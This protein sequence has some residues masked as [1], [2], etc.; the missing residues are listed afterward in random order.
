[1][2]TARLL[3]IGAVS[4]AAV[5]TGPAFASGNTY[6]SPLVAVLT[7]PQAPA[8]QYSAGYLDPGMRSYYS[9]MWEMARTARRQPY[10]YIPPTAPMPSWAAPPVMQAPPAM[11]RPMMQAPPAMAPH[12]MMAPPMQQPPMFQG[13]GQMGAQ[14]GVSR[15]GAEN[16]GTPSTGNPNG[17]RTLTPA[18]AAA[19]R[20]SPDNPANDPEEREKY[21][22]VFNNCAEYAAAGRTGGMLR[23]DPQRRGN[24]ELDRNGDGIACGRGD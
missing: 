12:P 17:P 2:R 18:E 6:D 19:Y 22:K 3:V 7:Y 11:Q 13:P 5:F 14:C 10:G 23:G 4:A 9:Y 20:C 24:P 8:P 21:T 1:M 16:W 15:G